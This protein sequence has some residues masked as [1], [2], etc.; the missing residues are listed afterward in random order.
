MDV[1]KMKVGMV[2]ISVLLAEM[3]AVSLLMKKMDGKG[4]IKLIALATSI[5]ILGQAVKSLGD[6]KWEEITKG[7]TSVGILLG[8][9]AAFSHLVKNSGMISSA[10]GIDFIFS[11]SI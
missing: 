2:G 3:T 4:S 10:T 8:E 9:L 6:L 1:A 11:S 7:L 5:L